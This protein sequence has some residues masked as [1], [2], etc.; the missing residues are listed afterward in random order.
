M[1]ETLLAM[2][3]ILATWIAWGAVLVCLGAA[4]LPRGL[5]VEPRNGTEQLVTAEAGA[6]L[7]TTWLVWF[8]SGWCVVVLFLQIWHFVQPVDERAAGVVAG[9]ALLAAAVRRRELWN[10][11]A[12]SCRFGWPLYAAIGVAVLWSNLATDEIRISDT[13]LYHMQAVR[14]NSAYPLVTGLGNL[15]GRLAFNNSSLLYAALLDI[16]PWSHRGHHVANGLLT[17]AVFLPLLASVRPVF[18]PAVRDSA[19]RTVWIR[20]VVR[21]LLIGP[22]LL[23]VGKHITSLAPEVAGV[24]LSTA[25]AVVLV[26][27]CFDQH[28]G[29]P[30]KPSAAVLFVA[31]L[32]ATAIT[33]KL[34]LVVVGVVATLAAIW[35]SRAGFKTS[36]LATAIFAI[37]IGPWCARG[38]LLSGYPAYP[39]QAGAFGVAWRVPSEL[40]QDEHNNI[41]AWARKPHVPAEEVLGNSDWV[42]PW[43]VRQLADVAGVSLPL[44]IAL[45]CAIACFRLRRREPGVDGPKLPR[46]WP[47]AL[48]FVAMLL[49][50]VVTAPDLWR[51]GGT[52]LWIIAIVAIA[53]WLQRLGRTQSRNAFGRASRIV[54]VGGIALCA[55]SL[56]KIVRYVRVTGGLAEIPRVE[57]RVFTSDS[58]LKLYVP[59]A[60]DPAWDAPLPST[61]YP[62]PRLELRTP[63]DLG[64]GFEIRAKSA[65][66]P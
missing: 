59:T 30:R 38:M 43:A 10:A 51:F 26:D 29:Q 47:A 7:P 14:W 35:L 53:A 55:V 33:V 20:H 45:G 12:A 4:I 49:F 24:L 57:L 19:D 11:L 3:A 6:D 31:L 39:A 48:P 46:L 42:G 37:A 23:Y 58:G 18:S 61:P 21:A 13:G 62:K 41:V 36:L 63:G 40:A 27:L 56:V 54:V 52:S 25:I 2:L 15:H 8:W 50:L 65:E 32:A 66:S 9:L 5:A 16:G 1:L 22:T 17:L 60:G 28:I 44:F 34:S 64:G